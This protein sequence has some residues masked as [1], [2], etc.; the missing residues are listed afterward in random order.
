LTV[1]P[2]LPATAAPSPSDARIRFWESRLQRDPE[3]HI[4]P[5]KLGAAYVQKARESGDP[6][7]YARAEQALRKSLERLPDNHEALATLASVQVG[8]HRFR[9][10]RELA[11]K[12]VRLHPDDAFSYGTLGDA[13]VELGDYE[14]SARS[15]QHMLELEPGLPAYARMSYQRELHGQ[16]KEALRLMGL[17]VAAAVPSDPHGGAWCRTQLGD[18]YFKGGDLDNAGRQYEAALKQLP[19][20]YLALV[21]QARVATARQKLDEAA[22]FLTRAIAAIPRPDFVAALGDVYALS[23]K[24]EQAR[25]QYDLVLQIEEV[26]RVAGV[27]DKRRLSLFYAN[28]DRDLDAALALAQQEYAVRQDV[29]TCD[30]FAWALYKKGRYPVAW[31]AA[32]RAMRLKTEDAAIHY[33]AGMI[34]ARLPGHSTDAERLLKRALALNPYFDPR[35]VPAAR[36]E[37]AALDRTRHDAARDARRQAGRKSP[38]AGRTAITKAAPAAPRLSPPGSYPDAHR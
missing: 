38:D 23:G 24:S 12:C 5:A 16:R 22:Q 17:A 4:T 33:H 9:E 1:W 27:P 20:Y 28:H 29:Y 14:A 3:D 13:Q 19:D 31:D 6:G 11:E 10:A 18:L 26:N 34:A 21:G 25:Q 37:L 2:G 8:Q 30:A 36:R 15:I 35:Q 32:Q 7:Y